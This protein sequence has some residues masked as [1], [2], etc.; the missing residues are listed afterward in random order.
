[1]TFLELTFYENTARAWLLAAAAA[2]LAIAGLL[3]IRSV[4]A[5]RLRILAEAL[6]ATAYWFLIAVGIWAGTL[7][8]VLPPALEVAIVTVVVLVLLVQTGLW[9]SKGIEGW[10]ASYTKRKIDED[11]ASVTTMR[12]V[13]FLGRM[14][15]WS[16]IL[17]V[18]LDNIGID[19]TALVAGLGVGGIAVA[20]AVQNVLGDLF[21]SLSIV[22]DKPFVVGDFIIVGDLLGTVERVGLKT[23]RVRSLSGEQLIFSNSDLL[24]SRIRNFKRMFERRV[25]F[26]FGVIYQTPYDQLQAI[27]GMVREIIESQE[28]TRF[29][30]AHFAK[31]GDSSL[32]FEVVYYVLVPDYNAYMDIQQTINLELFRRFETLGIDFAYPTRTLFLEPA[33][34]HAATGKDAALPGG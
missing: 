32:D 10:L 24:S 6:D 18:V 34:A 22:L 17:L 1:M 30:R 28:N 21:A 3:A 8:L 15:A 5:H 4:L 27:P 9:I 16:V 14:I 26:S 23:T 2:L 25:V 12:A 13:A 11:P 7:V 20:L 33:T 29:D 31:Y 19:V